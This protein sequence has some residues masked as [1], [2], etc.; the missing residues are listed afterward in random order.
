MKLSFVIWLSLLPSILFSQV[1]DRTQKNALGGDTSTVILP[2]F[3]GGTRRLY[4]YMIAN[5]IF[6]PEALA[7]SVSGHVSVSL[8]ISSKGK[9]KDIT[10]LNGLTAE[11]NKEAIRIVKSILAWNPGKYMGQPADM[12]ILITVPVSIIKNLNKAQNFWYNKGV[13]FLSANNFSESITCFNTALA[14]YEEDPDAHYNL[15]IAR[16]KSMEASGACDDW[17]RAYELGDNESKNVFL[18]NCGDSTRIFNIRQR[19]IFTV[20]DEMPGFPGGDEGLMTY[21]SKNIHYPAVAR[22]HGITGRVYVTFIVTE[23][24]RISNAKILRGI[25]GGCDEE[26]LRV[27]NEMPDWLPGKYHGK[28]VPVQYNIPISF[29]LK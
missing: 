8:T 20:V 13:D 29:S 10:V 4:E 14:L 22:E 16:L 23:T 11:C 12:K 3:Q 18:Q 28:R 6:P 1:V 17:I 7:D 24:G 25:G 21:L 15:G 5:Y 26:S 2:E 27:I 9:A 19:K